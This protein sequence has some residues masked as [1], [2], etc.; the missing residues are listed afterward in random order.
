MDLM[1]DKYYLLEKCAPYKEEILFGGI[2]YLG[3]RLAMK[4]IQWSFE[5]IGDNFMV[6][7]TSE[8][9]FLSLEKTLQPLILFGGLLYAS[10][11]TENVQEIF[12]YH[13]LICSGIIGGL[14]GI[15]NQT[16]KHVNE[17]K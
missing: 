7:S 3:G 16:N 15:L 12:N 6:S 8:R 4:F 17:N 10:I 9:F 1:Q 13:P 5:N 11:D 2:G 14:T